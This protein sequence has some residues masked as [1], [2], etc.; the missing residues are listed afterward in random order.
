M[1]WMQDRTFLTTWASDRRFAADA[2]NHI[3]RLNVVRNA[4]RNQFYEW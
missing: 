2:I 3:V 4:C 1:H